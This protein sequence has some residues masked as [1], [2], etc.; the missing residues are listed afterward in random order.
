MSNQLN[1]PVVSMTEELEK[2]L[3]SNLEL[4]IEF[5]NNKHVKTNINNY[6]VEINRFFENN[7]SYRNIDSFILVYDKKCGNCVTC[8]LLPLVESA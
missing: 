6:L 5:P 1:I 3:K 8:K 4:S 2:Y 7:I